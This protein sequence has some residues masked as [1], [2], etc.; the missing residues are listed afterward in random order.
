MA[1]AEGKEHIFKVKGYNKRKGFFFGI[2]IRG[3]LRP[4][5]QSGFLKIV[6]L[7]LKNCTFTNCL[8]GFSLGLFHG[9]N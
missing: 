8:T 2:E 5:K 3:Q 9:L 1:G 4:A 7:D 6:P